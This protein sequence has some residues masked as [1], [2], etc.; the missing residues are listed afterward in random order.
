LWKKEPVA[1][2][3]PSDWFAP[4]LRL[5]DAPD[6]PVLAERA[7]KR[8]TDYV[9]QAAQSGLKSLYR[10]K[11]V[12]DD[13]SASANVRAIAFRL[14][15]NGGLLHRDE[16]L[17]LTPEDK[18]VLKTQGIA[19]HRYAWFLPELQSPKIRPLLQAFGPGEVQRRHSQR[20]QL[21]L[22]DYGAV[23]L[24][25][26]SQLDKIMSH[27]LWRKGAT[28]VREA[29]FAPLSLNEKQRDRLM[30][31]LGL[32]KVEPITITETVVIAPQAEDAAREGRKRRKRRKGKSTETPAAAE[33]TDMPAGETAPEAVTEIAAEPTI[34]A[35]AEAPGTTV[36]ASEGLAETHEAQLLGWRQKSFEPRPPRDKPQRERRG[37]ATE[38]KPARKSKPQSGQRQERPH[39]DQTRKAPAVNPY[40]PFADLRARL[41]SKVTPEKVGQE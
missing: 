25:T 4:R 5:I 31:A 1:R 13:E 27:G 19:G 16:T 41:D 38:G 22:E 7:V 30:L 23:A 11:Q 39:R 32:V 18:A 34:E 15:E 17:K 9:R 35:S 29:A 2:I 28:Y 20:G 8:L 12:A 6:H 36:G 14:Y 21:L 24:K 33:T 40:S 10:M 26:L 37:E 3:E